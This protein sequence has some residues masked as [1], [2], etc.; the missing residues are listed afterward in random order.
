[1]YPAR[2]SVGDPMHMRKDAHRSPEPKT[3]AYLATTI[4]FMIRTCKELKPYV[5]D[6]TGVQLYP[7]QVGKIGAIFSTRTQSG[8]YG[9]GHYHP[10]GL[11]QCYAG[12][13]CVFQVAATIYESNPGNP[14]HRFGRC[15]WGAFL[16][17]VVVHCMNVSACMSRFC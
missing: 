15:N 9:K 5:M 4:E 11:I 10:T 13:P 8:R 7:D 6:Q 3:P 14:M 16:A 1:M 17:F 12:S 2:L